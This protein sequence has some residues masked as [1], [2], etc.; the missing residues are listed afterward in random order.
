MRDL[1]VALERYRRLG[2][3]VRA[4][5]GRQRYGFADRDGVSLHLAEQGHDHEHPEH[6]EHGHGAG[7][8]IG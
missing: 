3:A 7:D 6:A 2:F 5:A 1:D 4:Y 8:S